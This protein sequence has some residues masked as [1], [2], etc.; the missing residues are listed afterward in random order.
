MAS[1]TM[2][3]KRITQRHAP[4]LTSLQQLYEQ[5]F[6]VQERREFE[7]LLQLLDEPDMHLDVAVVGTRMAGFYIFWQF[8]SFCFLEHLA[9][10]PDLQGQGFGQQFLQRLLRE[11]GEKLVLE[12]E[13]PGD[14]TT[15]RRIRFYEGLGFTLHP[16]FDYYQPPYRKGQPPVP[17]Y[18]MTSPPLTD[19]VALA[20]LSRVIKQQVYERF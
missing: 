3:Y 2:V 12:V 8:E 16:G 20:W 9:I 18:L 1:P 11:A 7:Q 17:L 13:R 4:E 5:A 10:Q 15:R 19:A 14:E 6:P